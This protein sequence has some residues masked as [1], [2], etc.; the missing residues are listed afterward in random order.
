MNILVTGGCGFIGSNFIHHLLAKDNVNL[1]LNVDSMTYAS[2]IKNIPSSD[3]LKNVIDDIN[4]TETIKHLLHDNKITHVVHFAAESHVDNSIVNPNKFIVSNI[5]GTFSLLEAARAVGVDRFHHVST[6]EVYGSLGHTGK[7]IETT[8]YDPRSPYSASK[9]SSD[10]LVRSYYHTYGLNIT[11]SNCSNNY[12][13]RQHK[14][15]LIPKT[16]T[17]IIA[18]NKVPVYGAGTNVRDWLYV[19]DHCE[20][21][22][23]IISQGISGET[24]NIGGDC[25]MSNINIIATLCKMLNV[26]FDNVVE[27]VQDRKG[28]DFRYAIDHSKITSSLGWTPTTALRVGL[29][30]TIDFYLSAL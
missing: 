21:I 13:P 20:A 1:I 15:K 17:K 29:Q 5:N 19:Q 18:G 27:Y 11:I 6:D 3:R 26:E 23:Q 25:E 2:D 22:W 12:G 10:H 7:F 4:N 16:I 14:E 24:Y 8:P 30:K 9:A 28:H